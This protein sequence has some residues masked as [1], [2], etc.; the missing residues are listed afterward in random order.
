MYL[1][2]KTNVNHTVFGDFDDILHNEPIVDSSG[3]ELNG[4]QFIDLGFYP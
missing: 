2:L 4:S 3:V 1:S